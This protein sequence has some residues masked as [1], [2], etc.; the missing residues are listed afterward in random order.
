MRRVVALAEVQNLKHEHVTAA[1]VGPLWIFLMLGSETWSGLRRT[2]AAEILG[3]Q[4]FVRR[5][6]VQNEATA[7]SSGGTVR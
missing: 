1:S 4:W 2:S 3:S 6:Q 7:G 5:L